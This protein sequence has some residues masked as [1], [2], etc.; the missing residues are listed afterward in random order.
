MSEDTVLTLNGLR[1]EI[2]AGRPIVDG[3]SLSVRRGEVLAIVGESGSGKS[4]TALALLGYA[5]PGV[6]LVAGDLVVEGQ[7]VPI[8]DE[9]ASRSQRGVKISY[10][11]QDPAAAINPVRRVSALIR[12]MREVHS[13]SHDEAFVERQLHRVGLPGDEEFRH[14][15]AHQLSGGQRQRLAIAVALA[16]DPPVIILDEPTTA[17]DVV[18]QAHFREE[19]DRLRRDEGVG[20]VYITHDLASIAS[21]ADTVVVMYAGRVVERGPAAELLASP[22]HPYTAGLIASAPDVA[23]RRKLVPIPGTSGPAG[24]DHGGCS[25]A[26]R[27]SLAQPRCSSEDPP[28]TA[29]GR[30]RSVRCWESHRVVPIVVESKEARPLRE[31]APVLR[32]RGLSAEH[33]QAGAVVASVRNV[34]FDVGRAE[35]V[36]VVGASGSGKTTVARAIIGLHPAVAGEILLHDKP[37]HAQLRRR[38]IA[39]LRAVQMVFQNPYESLNPRRQVGDQVARAA[40]RLRGQSSRQARATVEDLFGLV[41]LSSRSMSRYPA[42]LSGGERQRIAIARALAGGPEIL[43]CDEITSALDVSVQAAVL[44]TLSELSA[45][46]G[47]STVFI[48]HDL[49]VVSTIADRVVVL[50]SGEV[51]ETGPVDQ[52]L[53]TPRDPYTRTLI[54]AAPR[55]PT[56]LQLGESRAGTTV[57]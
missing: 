24:V 29:V 45:A 20:V 11:P 31:E 10:V 18:A 4:T 14:R 30:E 37:V 6:R 50:E 40:M 36:A 47:L 5:R 1:A 25:F 17:L 12:E 51:R 23:T 3:V 49:G 22:S 9:R 46:L 39:D 57:S 21:L 53:R 44:D 28:E 8:D 34:S 13:L 7:T 55:M 41:R 15:F 26:E 42:E 27:C 35:C 33:R 43:I 2:S 56:L 19:V 32:V 16:C 38:P 54:E 52:V 48:T